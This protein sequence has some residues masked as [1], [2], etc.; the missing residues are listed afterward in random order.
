MT[1]SAWPSIGS[2]R[3]KRDG[4]ICMPRYAH[5]PDPDPDPAPTLTLNP[6]PN[7]NLYPKLPN[8]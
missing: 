6:N 8:P 1:A 5:N 7:P 4:A 3:G 2:A